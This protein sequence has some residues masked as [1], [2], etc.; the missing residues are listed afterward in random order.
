[1]ASTMVAFKVAP[2]TMVR[3]L[4]MGDDTGSCNKPES[5]V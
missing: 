3:N 2:L 4:A 5:A 1:M